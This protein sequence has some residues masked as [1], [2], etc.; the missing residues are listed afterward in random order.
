MVDFKG[1]GVVQV[2]IP[3]QQD[4][5]GQYEYKLSL[6]AMEGE[7][8]L[9]N[10]VHSTFVRVQPRR[11]RVLLLDGAPFWDTKFIAQSLR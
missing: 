6:K 10:N 9:A 1:R 2:E 11:M 7:V 3:V 5:P 8:E 4:M